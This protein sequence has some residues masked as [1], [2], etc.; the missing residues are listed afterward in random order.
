M[1]EGLSGIEIGEHSKHGGDAVD[2]DRH[3]RLLSI[4]EAV[5]LS[6]VAVLAAYSGYASGQVGYRVIGLAGQGLGGTH[7]G[8]PRRP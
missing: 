7:E 1:P 5:L 3:E 2:N 6:L 8:Q 4:T